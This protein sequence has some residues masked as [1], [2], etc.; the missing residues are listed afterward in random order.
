MAPGT[1]RRS[2]GSGTGSTWARPR[3]PWPST[4]TLQRALRPRSDQCSSETCGPNR[5]DD[6]VAEPQHPPVGQ[7]DHDRGHRRP[8]R[9]RADLATGEGHA[10]AVLGEALRLP[11]PPGVREPAAPPVLLAVRRPAVE[12]PGLLAEH[13]GAVDAAAEQPRVPVLVERRHRLEHARPTEGAPRPRHR[14][15]QAGVHARVGTQVDVQ[16]IGGAVERVPGAG[17]Q[18]VGLGRRRRGGPACAGS[19]RGARPARGS[20]SD[21]PLPG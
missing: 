11:P 6:R 3:S 12:L 18:P 1:L 7:P 17:T 9:T 10:D 14:I 4:S 2:A 15:H 13:R 20:P 5:G 16:R 21:R 8:Q 19:R